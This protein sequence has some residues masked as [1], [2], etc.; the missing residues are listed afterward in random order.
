[1]LSRVHIRMSYVMRYCLA[2]QQTPNIPEYAMRGIM[3]GLPNDTL[4][5]R[6]FRR[7]ASHATLFPASQAKLEA[8]WLL[9]QHCIYLRADYP[10]YPDYRKPGLHL[11]K[12]RPPFSTPLS[13]L[14]LL[15]VLQQHA[16]RPSSTP[17]VHAFSKD[18]T[19][20]LGVPAITPFRNTKKL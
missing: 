12:L 11:Q 5:R 10:T 6:A 1:M 16:T 8:S 3:R 9:A 2:A 4:P 18:K 13:S 19:K 17:A 7:K 14:L 20:Q 15:S